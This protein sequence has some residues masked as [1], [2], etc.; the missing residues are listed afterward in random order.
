MNVKKT[1]ATEGMKT[2]S[3]MPDAALTAGKM[4]LR[5]AMYCFLGALIWG[6]AFVAQQVGGDEIPALA[7]VGQ[8]FLMGCIVLL[9]L[10]AMRK[11]ARKRRRDQGDL[12]AQEPDHKQAVIGG[13]V[14]GTALMVASVLQQA[15]I[16]H[17]A[18]GKA[19]FL[20]ALYIIMVPLLSLIFTRRSSAKVWIAAV[21]AA[22]G[23]Y[24][25]C[26]KAGER[27]SIGPWELMLLGCALAFS[28]Q[29]MSVDYF[30][31]RTDGVE[32]ACIQFLVTGLLGTAAAALHGE[33][34]M[35]SV[36]TQALLSLCYAGIFSS[37]IA[38][39][40]QVVGQKG[41]DPAIASLIMSL[42]SVISAVSGF[43]LLHQALSAREL[44]GCVLMSGAI[45]LV[46]MPLKRKSVHYTETG[47]ACG[48][49]EEE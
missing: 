37:G 36:S 41:A 23:L 33:L 10:V 16:A 13:L 11:R 46:Q 35:Q 9:P 7:F 45:V 5:N 48:E 18:V 30:A 31:V 26:S 1:Q 40:L 28:I 38:Y 44:V 6:T 25:L 24:C 47:E 17:V 4:P 20:T 32:L 12:H 39:T 49:T 8:R 2:A 42:E 34:P 27:F 43:F 22:A 15:A 29:I 14:C 19:G 3:D 21:I